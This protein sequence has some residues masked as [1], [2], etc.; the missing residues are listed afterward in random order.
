MAQYARGRGYGVEVLEESINTPVLQVLD[1]LM[2]QDWDVYGFSVHIWS[3]S[4]VERLVALLRRVSPNVKI[5]LGGPEAG[6]V[7]GRRELYDY[8]IEG[9]GEERF[10]EVLQGLALPD[11]EQF[12]QD[13]P[14][15]DIEQVK[16]QHKI[17]YYEASRGCPF[18]CS[19]CLSSVGHRV[20]HKPLS[21]VLGDLE[22]F[23]VADVDLVKFVDRT[24]NLDESF[25]LPTMRFLAGVNCHTTF[26]FEIKAD[27]LGKEVLDFLAIVPKGRF[28]FEVGI[29]S[30]HPETLAAIHRSN[31]WEKLRD[32]CG[33][34]LSYGN[35]H[36]HTD[37]IAGLPYEG[38]QQWRK[39]FNDVYGIGAPMLQLGF[40]KVLPGTEMAQRAQEYGLVY[41]PEPPYEILATRW[42]S[43]GDLQFLRK[44]DKIFDV[45][46][47]GGHFPNYLSALV[48]E[49]AEPY[50]FYKFL[51]DN[52]TL[53]GNIPFNAKTL[54]RGLFQIFGNRHVDLLQQDIYQNIHNWKPEWLDWS[55]YTRRRK[56]VGQ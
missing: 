12:R 37:L 43:Y 48:Q 30:T 40:L 13:F 5:V 38:L 8:L 56:G 19:Y 46:H 11:G 3:R 55:N 45:V 53:E 17:F 41:M 31:D 36:L 1:Q 22:K 32:N 29:Q 47:N 51:T 27:L 28:Q 44:F 26:H 9:D 6:Q 20:R 34:I 49:F 7:K 24:F 33:R 50:E 23:V 18:R 42:M 35:I 21:Q 4:Y 15:P 10:C 52:W 54:A 39:S 14:Y 25:Y 16:A 2:A